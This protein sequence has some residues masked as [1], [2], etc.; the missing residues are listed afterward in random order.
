MKGFPLQTLTKA[1]SGRFL[2]PSLPR[3]AAVLSLTAAL[4]PLAGCLGVRVKSVNKTVLAPNVQR[5]TL[6]QLLAKMG[7]SY[8]AVKGL[9]LI[10]TIAATEG[11]AHQ[12]EVKELPSFRGIILLRKPED[13]HV[14]MQLPFVGSRALDMV[15][16]GKNFKLYIAAGK[17]RAIVG[18][19][20][21]TTPSKNGLENLR[22]NIIRDALQIPPLGPG[23]LVTLTE[24][25]RILPP[26]RGHKEAI[27][28]P[29][30]D[31][32]VLRLA[33]GQAHPN[34]L[35]RVR[36]VHISRATLLP[37]QQDLYDAEGRIVTII[38]YD[39]YQ[40]F[41]DVDYPMDVFIKRPLD[42]YTLRIGITKLV[43]N[44][45]LA[46][47]QF[48]LTIPDTVPIQKM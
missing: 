21:I 7:A 45:P 28:E 5:A 35:E 46:D 18:P 29:D 20:T 40:K 24:D 10:V 31:L 14:I 23:E 15:S 43:L 12:G 22:P 3:L 2:L 8:A 30:Y 47:D 16:D 36:V 11:G 42:E 26:L 37:Y 25:S 38:T 48:T 1:H 13:L 32:S 44:P 19:E 27:E 41:G 17:A 33:A 34:V 9:Q 6:D 4:L 39:K